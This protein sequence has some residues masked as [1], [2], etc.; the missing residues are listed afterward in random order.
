MPELTIRQADWS[1]VHIL[2]D[3]DLKCFDD[4]WE[5]G[6]WF[7]WFAETRMVFIVEVDGK[8]AGFAIGELNE[9]GL[10]VEK[11]GVKPLYRR[12]GVS[13]MLLDGCDDL[14]TKCKTRPKIYLIVPEPWLYG[15][16]PD[17]VAEWMKA[18]NIKARLPYLPEYFCINEVE[19]DGIRCELE[20]EDQS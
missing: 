17:C 13:R 8:P 15:D 11:L 9:D 2:Q 7:Y 16:S 19:F 10:V 6:Y 3:M 20:V 4:P 1:D 14:T 12:L 18:M 5:D